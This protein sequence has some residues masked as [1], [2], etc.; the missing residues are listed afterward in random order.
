MRVSVAVGRADTLYCVKYFLAKLFLESVGTFILFFVALEE[1]L[2]WKSPWHVDFN[3]MPVDRW[4]LFIDVLTKRHVVR[5]VLSKRC[6]KQTLCT[7]HL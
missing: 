4:V 3:L 6:I 1:C 5:S 2:I 7:R